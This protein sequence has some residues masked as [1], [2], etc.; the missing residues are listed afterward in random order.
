[1]SDACGCGHDEPAGEDEQAPEHW[2]Q[3]RELQ[4]AA[5][6]AVFVLAGYSVGWSGGPH[7]LAVVLQWVALLIG[8]FTFVPSTLQRL[9]RGKIGV[10]TLMTIAAVGAVILGEVGEAAML[11]VLFS[12][13]EGLEEYALCRTRRGLRA[14]LSLV[15]DTATVLRASLSSC[16]CKSVRCSI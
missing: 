10:G 7:P 11:A 3:V 1:M 5:A 4:A 2:W 6:A 15:P 9:V 14:L 12:I 16:L 13:S 8:A